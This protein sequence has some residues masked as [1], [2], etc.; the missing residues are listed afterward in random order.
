MGKHVLDVGN[1]SFDHSALK[2]VIESHFDARVSRAHGHTDA[3]QALR[4][5][6]YQLVLINRILDRDG[7]D[8]LDLIRRIKS[9][10]DLSTKPVMLI[11]NYDE[12]QQ[13]AMEAGAERGFGKNSIGSPELIEHLARFLDKASNLT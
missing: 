9:E 6:D 1:C 4:S 2:R 3:L 8:G 5:G 12:Y 10:T 7:S 13:R 11:T